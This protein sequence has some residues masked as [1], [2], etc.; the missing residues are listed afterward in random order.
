MRR[1]VVC[2]DGTWNRADQERDG[3]P[4]P[5]NVVEL[6]F[7]SATSD[8]GTPQIIYYDQGVGVGNWL[9]RLRGGAFGEGLEANIHDAYRFLVANYQPRDEIFLFGF[10]RGAF[11]ARSIAGM[12]RKCGILGRGAVARYG[13][14]LALYRDADHPDDPAPKA[15]RAR[16]S[17][18]GSDP[19]EIRFIGVWDTV[20]ALGIPVRGLGWLSRD[21]YRF[22]DTEL[23]GSVK[24]AYHALSIDERRGPFAPTL[25]ATKPKEGQTVEQCWFCGV[26]SDVG[27][28]YVERGPAD[29]S[30]AW[31]LDKARDAGLALA[32]EAMAAYPLSPEPVAPLHDSMTLLYRIGSIERTIGLATRTDGSVAEGPPMVDERQ[33]LHPSVRARWDADARYRP[34]NLRDYF[35]IIGDPRGA[36]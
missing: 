11:T 12:I 21:K 14:A 15:F 24:S 36:S 6:A 8:G 31:L 29:I 17:C 28:G 10:S 19:I 22:H 34:K 32:P 9:D 16:N 5:T 7:R 25:W 30:L 33:T 3:V 27:G 1:L 23:S 35:R 13:A 20:G 18:T 26:H 2:C 4:C